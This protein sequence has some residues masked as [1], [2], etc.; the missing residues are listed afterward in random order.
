MI[1]LLMII[2]KSI[3]AQDPFLLS[4]SGNTQEFF[5][6]VTKD[7]NI[8]G[9]IYHT[10]MI[11]LSGYKWITSGTAGVFYNTGAPFQK[12]QIQGGNI[13]LCR[14][15]SASTAPDLNPTS[16]NG[17]ILFSDMV[18][19]ANNW[20]HGKWGIEYDDQY[21][22]GGLNFFNP[23]SSLTAERKNF[24]LFISNGGNIGVGTGLPSAKLQVANGDI[25]I[26]DINRGIIMK[27]PDGNCWRGTL[28]NQGQLEFTLLPDCLTT[29]VSENEN[30]EKPSFRISPNP[31][32]D[33]IQIGCSSDLLKEF[34]EYSLFDS[35][36]NQIK[37]GRMDNT[38]FKI[39]I[40]GIAPGS[41]ILNFSG[42]RKFWSEKII[43]R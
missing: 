41:Y 5:K 30:E 40:E 10:G 8:G 38:M 1:F 12:L 31:A 2:G 21:S 35:T 17:A 36:G 24:N 32:S 23:V 28:N 34:R 19:S 7:Y 43:I 20:I 37:T 25:F 42:N 13:L 39:N 27:S 9:S 14:T 33:F 18:I 15:N 6:Y 16:R 3:T 29:A 4:P 22:T 11:N 26:E